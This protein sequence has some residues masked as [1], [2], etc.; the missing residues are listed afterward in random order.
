ML[1]ASK[2]SLSLLVAV[3][4]VPLHNYTSGRLNWVQLAACDS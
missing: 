2:Y 1:A 4:Y 3:T